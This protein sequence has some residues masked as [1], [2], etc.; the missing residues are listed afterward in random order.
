METMKKSYNIRLSEHDRT[1]WHALTTWLGLRNT[2]AMIR[3]LVAAAIR[4]KKKSE[5]PL[6]K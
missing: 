3:Y 5:K 2:A 4:D 1:E 6:D